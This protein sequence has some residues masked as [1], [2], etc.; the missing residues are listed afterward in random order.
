VI[1]S[2]SLK[3]AIYEPF[4]LAL[5]LVGQLL[6]FC[7]W[8]KVM[9]NISVID[10]SSHRQLV[11]EAESVSKPKLLTEAEATKQ[12]DRIAPDWPLH[13]YD[14]GVIDHIL[15]VVN[16]TRTSRREIMRRY[17]ARHAPTRSATPLFRH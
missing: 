6:G 2:I 4:P 3:S 13:L 9:L 8:T 16:Q 5:P 7:L 14:G 12:L 10:A 1:F 15:K 17:R 11:R